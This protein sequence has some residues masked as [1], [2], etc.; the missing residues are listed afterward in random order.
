[1]KSYLK[2]FV[3]DELQYSLEHPLTL[4][5]EE[6]IHSSGVQKEPMG[7]LQMGTLSGQFKS[8]FLVSYLLHTR[9]FLSGLLS[10]YCPFYEYDLNY[11]LHWIFFS[12]FIWSNVDNLKHFSLWWYEVLYMPKQTPVFFTTVFFTIFN[13]IYNATNNWKKC[14]YSNAILKKM[15][16]LQCNLFIQIQTNS[17]S[18][19][20]FCTTMQW[21]QCSCNTII[22]L[23]Q[24]HVKWSNFFVTL[25][26]A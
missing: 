18:N 17:M 14:S 2:V 21:P 13:H 24:M 10:V 26:S 11:P 22:A 5:L 12:H 19:W 23:Q 6:N 15:L 9:R 3:I 16:L 7:K 25:C 20:I 4:C 8:D 1:M